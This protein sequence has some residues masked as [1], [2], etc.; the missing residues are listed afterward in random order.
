MDSVLEQR[1]SAIARDLTIPALLHRNAT[2]FPDHPA[3]SLLGSPGTLT[4]RELRDEIAV[5]AR[6]LADLG[7]RSGDRML[8]MMSSRPEHWLIDLAAVHLGAVPST[9]YATLSTD[10]L[11]YLARHSRAAIVVLE[12]EAA[13]DRWAPILADVPE[14]RRVVVADRAADDDSGRI[15]ALRNV[16]VRGAAAHQADPAAFE[17]T[18][19]EVRPD[20]PVTL[21][22]TSGTT[23]DPK[24]VVL[25]H[26][27]VV[28]QTVVMEHTIETPAHAASLAY[29]PLAHIAERV[30]GVYN[31][32]YRAGHVTI[33]PDPTQLLAGLVRIRPV[34]FFGVPRI[35]EKMVAGVQGRLA[36]AEPQVKA[37]VDMARAVALQ[38]HEIRQA[39]SEIPAEL[40]AKHAILDAQVLKPLRAGLGLDNML[41]AGSGAAPIPVEVLLYLASIGVDVLEVW[42]MTETTGT[43][44]INTPDHFRTGTVGRPNGGMQIRLADDGE[45]LVRGPLVCAGYLRADGGVDPVTDAD[46]WLATGDVGVFDSDGYLTITDRKKELIIN[47]S[48]K[49]ISPAQ[50]E[51][52]LRA[53]PLIAQ[54]VAIG[55]RQPYVT[56]LIVLDEETAPI[57][58]GAKGLSFGTLADL[59][60]DPVLRAEIDAAVSTANSRLSRPEQV[61]TYRI[62]SR[63]WTP[64]TGELTPTLKLRRRIIQERYAGEIGALYR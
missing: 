14:I 61:K 57:W 8:I 40:A 62:L 48:G 10:Q 36:T 43:A 30:L 45:I 21:L 44:T 42:G 41:W 3:L 59:A 28:Y 35:W 25:T 54:A 26:R 46:G 23:G 47:S 38:V 13:L 9:V 55:D 6:G 39:G 12:D 50:I 5:L 4:W 18:W 32:I 56:A 15:V 29:L 53:H 7:L 52:L 2:D 58:A 27:N 19:R 60:D 37:A 20:Q 31:P 33:C 1:C 51:N 11:H 63:G 64:E 34:S 17:K 16:S 24:G 49:N 22:Y